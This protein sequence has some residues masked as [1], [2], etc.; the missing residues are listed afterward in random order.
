MSTRT[1]LVCDN[2]KQ[3]ADAL[4]Y[5]I[6]VHLPRATVLWCTHKDYGFCSESCGVE[7]VSAHFEREACKKAKAK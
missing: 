4:P 6:A 1:I 7:W 5:S 2:C 3:D